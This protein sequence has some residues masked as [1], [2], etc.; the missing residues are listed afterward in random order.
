MEMEKT[1]VEDATVREDAAVG[2][3][4]EDIDEKQTKR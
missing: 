2:E 4:A 3:D 1:V